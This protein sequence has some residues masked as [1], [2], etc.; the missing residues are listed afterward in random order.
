MAFDMT[1]ER[2]INIGYPENIRKFHYNPL[3]PVR[4]LWFDLLYGNLL[5]VDGFGNI[6]IGV[7]GFRYMKPFVFIIF[8][9]IDKFFFMI[10]LM[11]Y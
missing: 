1:V 4:G 3:F 2:L 5:K 7:H 8:F 11:K 9:Y 6:L 10:K